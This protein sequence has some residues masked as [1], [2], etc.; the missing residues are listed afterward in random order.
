MQTLPTPHP[1]YET[2]FAC[3][4]GHLAYLYGC[5]DCARERVTISAARKSEVRE[6]TQA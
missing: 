3:D 6:M 2:C 5:A 4:A 1:F